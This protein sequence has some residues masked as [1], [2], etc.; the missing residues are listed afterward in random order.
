[1]YKTWITLGAWMW[2]LLFSGYAV[3]GGAGALNSQTAPS[4][5][6]ITLP[7]GEVPGP[8]AVPVKK[9]ALQENDWRSYFQLQQAYRGCLDECTREFEACMNAAGEDPTK[10]FRCGEKRYACTLS[11]DNKQYE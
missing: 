1:M 11:C 6:G 10:R 4:P 2:V 7:A 8:D 5:S 3:A 9:A